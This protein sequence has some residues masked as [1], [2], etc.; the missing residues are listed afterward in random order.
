M[1]RPTHPSHSLSSQYPATEEGPPTN[2]P[3]RIGEKFLEWS[4]TD[5]HIDHIL[6]NIS[7]YWFTSSILTSLQPYR[8]L[9]GQSG[10]KLTYIEK[11]IGFSFFPYELFPGIKHVLEKNGNIVTYEQHESGGHFAALEKPK[12]L[13]GDVEKYVEAVWGKV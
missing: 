4:D 13:W 10:F 3:P 6:T 5:P 8:Q 1:V 7:L 2:I 12:E 9:H 11:P